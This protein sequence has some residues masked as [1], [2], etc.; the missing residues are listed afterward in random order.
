MANSSVDVSAV[1]S[2]IAL[3]ELL[4]PQKITVVRNTASVDQ[5]LRVLAQHRI[6]SAPV[7]TKSAESSLASLSIAEEARNGSGE[8]GIGG[9]GGSG[10]VGQDGELLVQPDS[11]MTP[12]GQL[13]GF[14]DI[15]DVLSSFLKELDMGQI[16]DAKMLRR[17]RI[18]EEKGQVCGCVD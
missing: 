3:E 8:G 10:G 9:R 17:M 5:T 1:L 7:R 18:L 14:I 4:F 6:L 12:S 15:R 11:P 13:S 16:E 2:E